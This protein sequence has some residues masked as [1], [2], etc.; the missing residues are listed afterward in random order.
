MS[1]A[2]TQPA[3]IPCATCG[4]G[5]STHFYEPDGTFVGA[6]CHEHARSRMK[7]ASI[8]PPGFVP[9]CPAAIGTMGAT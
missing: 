3:A 8:A 5:A 7:R 4:R 6:Y 1:D 9:K 2:I